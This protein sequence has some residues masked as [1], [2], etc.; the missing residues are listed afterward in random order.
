MGIPK[1]VLLYDMRSSSAPALLRLPPSD[2]APLPDLDA[3]HGV[4]SI[5]V[6]W[7]YQAMPENRMCSPMAVDLC[8]VFVLG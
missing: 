2:A 1:T 3:T 4:F 7:E 5:G 6:F 8:C